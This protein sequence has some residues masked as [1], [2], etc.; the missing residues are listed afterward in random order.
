MEKLVAFWVTHTE[1]C[2][3]SFD[4]M[5]TAGIKEVESKEAGCRSLCETGLHSY[6]AINVTGNFSVE[7]CFH[8]HFR[9]VTP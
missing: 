4:F 6:T 1:R 9:E 8:L 5:N 7:G 3:N 2:Q